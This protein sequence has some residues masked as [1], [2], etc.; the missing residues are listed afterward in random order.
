MNYVGEMFRIFEFQATSLQA[1]CIKNWKGNAAVD[2]KHIYIYT[3]IYYG[4]SVIHS[5]E[6]TNNLS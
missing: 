6:L 4:E 5:Y 1:Q 2:T 3:C